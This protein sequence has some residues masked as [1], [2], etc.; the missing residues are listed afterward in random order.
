[1][2]ELFAIVHVFGHVSVPGH[3]IAV[4][5]E[6]FDQKTPSTCQAGSNKPSFIYICLAVQKLL[7]YKG[8]NLWNLSIYKRLEVFPVFPL[9]LNHVRTAGHT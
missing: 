9:T 7:R 8:K 6:I 2:S 4:G 5:T 1:M 3:S